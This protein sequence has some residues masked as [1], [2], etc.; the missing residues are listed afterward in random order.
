MPPWQLQRKRYSSEGLLSLGVGLAEIN[1]RAIACDSCLSAAGCD[2]N[3]ANALPSLFQGM[4]VFQNPSTRV[5]A[6]RAW[7]WEPGC[8]E[9][10][11]HL[12]AGSP[13]TAPALLVSGQ[14][15]MQSGHCRL[16]GDQ[17][18]QHLALTGQRI[19]HIRPG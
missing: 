15:A 1:P 2:L 10:C 3:V 17:R 6:V 4:S 7:R 12:A 16:D 8:A 19:S 5:E 13:S 11:M 14:H 9:H 18:M